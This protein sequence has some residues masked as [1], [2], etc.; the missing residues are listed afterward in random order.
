MER[1]PG[2]ILTERRNTWESKK[3]IR[4]LYSKWY[5]TIADALKPGA[6]LELGG[7]S[8]NLKDFFPDTISSDV[9]FAPWLDAVL[10]AQALPFQNESLDGI[11]LFDVLHH[12]S[13]PSL[14]F[15]EAQRVLSPGGR[16]VMMEPYV[17]WFSY[18]IYRFFHQEGLKWKVD[19]FHGGSPDGEKDPF[20]GNQAIPTLIFEKHRQKFNDGFPGFTILRREVTDFLV[21]PLSG[22]FHHPTLFPRFMLPA[23]NSMENLLRPLGRFMAFRLFIVVEKGRISEKET[24]A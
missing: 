14:F 10:D 11:V 15:S 21:Y 9:L 13:R 8:G 20:A 23:L 4:D 18:L 16:L 12:L 3:V 19:P 6:T 2:D 5:G 7:G 24:A 1:D 17:S 22:G